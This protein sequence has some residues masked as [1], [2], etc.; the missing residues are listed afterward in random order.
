V[1]DP[2]VDPA[3][4]S[5]A[6]TPPIGRF[7]TVNVRTDANL[8]GSRRADTAP[9]DIRTPPDDA[10][11]VGIHCR[12]HHCAGGT[13]A[14]TVIADTP[15]PTPVTASKSV[16]CYS[17]RR[18]H[19]EMTSASVS[20]GGA[21]PGHIRRM[22]ETATGHSGSGLVAAANHRRTTAQCRHRP[23]LHR[24]WPRAG[25]EASPVAAGHE[26]RRRQSSHSGLAARKDDAAQQMQRSSRNEVGYGGEAQPS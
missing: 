15:R 11:S 3:A 1:R 26:A 7:I 8:P 12:R 2:R 6:S 9:G 4:G 23:A 25:I 17:T 22:G 20:G 16:G 13:L 19:R 14:P 24:R 21:S 10:A 5:I 18:V